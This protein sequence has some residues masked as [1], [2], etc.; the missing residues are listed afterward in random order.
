MHFNFGSLFLAFT[1]KETNNSGISG[2]R[3]ATITFT[4]SSFP[5]STLIIVGVTVRNSSTFSNPVNKVFALSNVVLEIP[6]N[7]P[8]IP[9]IK[10][11]PN[12]NRV[13]PRTITMIVVIES[14]IAPFFVI[15]L[16]L[17]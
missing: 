6:S 11:N 17:F 5:C 15:K 1:R 3:L 7:F 8:K 4:T 14:S 12:I 10:A 2:L 9:L 13:T 16:N